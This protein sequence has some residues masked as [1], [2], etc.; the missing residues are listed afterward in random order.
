VLGLIL[1]VILIR[2]GWRY[3][4]VPRRLVWGLHLGAAILLFLLMP[5]DELGGYRYATPFL[6]LIYPTVAL[7]FRQVLQQLPWAEW[8]RPLRPVLVA[9]GLVGTALLGVAQTWW[10]RQEPP[11]SMS[12]AEARYV[13]P[14]AEA[15]TV[16]VPYPGAAL[17]TGAFTVYDQAGLLDTVLSHALARQ[18]TAAYRR[19]LVQD[20]TPQYLILDSAWLRGT[21]LAADSAF[22]AT[23]RALPSDAAQFPLPAEQ[24]IFVRRE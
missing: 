1:M 21:R 22:A 13:T 14:F 8:S 4:L 3:Q 7:L 2:L 20:L 15:D 5:C 11:L 10:H 19:R 24:R 9:V 6:L 12:V 16:L 23:Y 18:D 17:W